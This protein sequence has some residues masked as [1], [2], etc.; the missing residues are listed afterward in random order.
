[1]TRQTPKPR[2]FAVEITSEYGIYRAA[3][4]RW[5]HGRYINYTV[6]F[7]A[8][9]IRDK[10]AMDE[11]IDTLKWYGLTFIVTAIV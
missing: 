3:K 8:S 7:G 5:K 11:Y 10:K 1:M 4:D 9:P 6:E 2:G